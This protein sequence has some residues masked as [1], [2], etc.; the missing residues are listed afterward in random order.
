MAE[1]WSYGR[2]RLRHYVARFEVRFHC[3]MLMT[4][5]NVFMLGFV[6]ARTA[7]AQT[8][9]ARAGWVASA[10]PSSSSDTPSKAIDGSASTRFS[11]GTDQVPGQWFSLDMITQQ[12]FSQITI[13]PGSSTNDFT[14]ATQSISATAG[15]AS[16]IHSSC[17]SWPTK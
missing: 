3:S 13:D 14:K 11:S 15:S 1:R 7:E 5:R 9:L 16:T 8:P 4:I 17:S 6:A 2:G 12:T 10:V